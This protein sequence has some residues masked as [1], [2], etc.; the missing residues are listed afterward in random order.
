MSLNS[1]MLL[2]TCGVTFADG[3]LG[4]PLA[5]VAADPGLEDLLSAAVVSASSTTAC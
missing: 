4:V 3:C 2:F 5:D 1:K